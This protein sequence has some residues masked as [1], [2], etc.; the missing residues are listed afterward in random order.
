MLTWNLIDFSSGVGLKA[1]YRTT[2]F[3]FLRSRSFIIYAA[4]TPDQRVDIAGT[5]F[6]IYISI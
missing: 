6:Y 2:P 4:A 3:F 5:S 1:N